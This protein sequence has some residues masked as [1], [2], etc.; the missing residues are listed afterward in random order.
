THTHAAG[1]VEEVHLSHVDLSYREKLPDLILKAVSLAK[2]QLIPA[3]VSFGQVDVPEHLRCRRYLMKHPYKPM[4]PVT[5]EVDEIKT[6]PFGAEA[7][8]DSPIAEV[9]PG[10]AFLGVKS[11]EDQWISILGNYS[12]HYVGDWENGTISADYFGVFS[13]ALK[14][15]L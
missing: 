7:L 3:K 12:L 14:E 8:I 15:K 6:N 11:L 9:D 1:A 2:S 10:L 4:N 13:N 5:G